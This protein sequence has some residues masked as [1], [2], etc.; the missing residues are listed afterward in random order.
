MVLVQQA[1]VAR[2]LLVVA[3]GGATSSDD[4]GGDLGATVGRGD[5]ASQAQAS[6][7]SSLSWRPLYVVVVDVDIA[8]VQVIVQG[9]FVWVAPFFSLSFASR[10]NYPTKNCSPSCQERLT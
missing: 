9:W 4:G 2:C 7:S 3:L 1:I 6:A 10:G 8:A 5:L